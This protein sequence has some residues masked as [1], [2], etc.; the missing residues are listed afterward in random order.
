M[1]TLQF[2]T[3]R[4]KKGRPI[5][6]Y[7]VIKILH[8]IGARGKKNYMYKHVTVRNERLFA[9]HLGRIKKGESRGFYLTKDLLDEH[10]CWPECEV[11]QTS[12]WGSSWL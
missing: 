3:V 6:E 4:D 5:H 2:A 7:D 11:V 10:G 9:L 12:A 8:F 1:T